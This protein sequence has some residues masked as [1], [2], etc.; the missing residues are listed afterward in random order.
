[1]FEL[2][3]KESVKKDFH[4]IGKKAAASVMQAI[5][6]KLLPD[7]KVAGKALK[8]QDGVLWSFRAG[9]YRVLY[10]FDEK[11]LWVL[12]V[13]IGHRKDVYKTLPEL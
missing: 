12:V 3:F 9:D 7:P 1:M 10:V 11:E 8:G 5:R 4:R 13:R 6:E 2:R